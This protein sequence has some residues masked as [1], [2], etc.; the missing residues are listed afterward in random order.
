MHNEVSEG[1]LGRVFNGLG[2]AIDGGPAPVGDIERNVPQGVRLAMVVAEG[3]VVDLDH[4][5]F[6]GDR[7]RIV[8]HGGCNGAGGVV[9]RI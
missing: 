7:V 2:R 5:V 6:L 8:R 3:N 4:R 9:H 1:M